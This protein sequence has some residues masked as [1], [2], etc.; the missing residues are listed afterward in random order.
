MHEDSHLK[1]QAGNVKRENPNL[2]IF[3]AFLAVFLHTVL[4]G[5]Q[6]PFQVSE[7]RVHGLLKYL[8]V[9]M[10]SSRQLRSCKG[11]ISISM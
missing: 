5:N 3:Y 6:R 11:A 9:I 4:P 2:N 8:K 10:H 7:S 1:V